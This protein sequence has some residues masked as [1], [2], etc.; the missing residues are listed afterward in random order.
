MEQSQ[1]SL[2]RSYCHH[3]VIEEKVLIWTRDIGDTKEE[4]S[5]AYNQ[6]SKYGTPPIKTHLPGPK[7]PILGLSFHLSSDIRHAVSY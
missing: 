4:F 1:K 7:D 3:P 6:S 2:A 5:L